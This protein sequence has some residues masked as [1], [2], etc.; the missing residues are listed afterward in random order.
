MSYVLGASMFRGARRI[1]KMAEQLFWWLP[2]VGCFSFRWL[3]LCFRSASTP[4]PAIRLP[5]SGAKNSRSCKTRISLL[6]IQ[7]NKDGFKK[8]AENVNY[9]RHARDAYAIAVS[10]IPCL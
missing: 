9:R 3:P 10:L 2:L 8:R 1:S 7:S 6:E 5:I 4:L